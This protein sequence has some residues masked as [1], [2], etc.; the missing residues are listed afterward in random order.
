MVTTTVNGSIY[1][2]D[3]KGTDAS[4]VICPS[5]PPVMECTSHEYVNNNNNII[6]SDTSRKYYDNPRQ[7]VGTAKFETLVKLENPRAWPFILKRYRMSNESSEKQYNIYRYV[8]YIRRAKIL[9]RH[10]NII[11]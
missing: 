5:N 4:R 7:K 11:I 1:T 6:L 8:Y 9:K 10:I 3:K 2:T